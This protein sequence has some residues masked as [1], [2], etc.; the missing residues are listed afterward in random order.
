MGKENFEDFLNK[1]NESIEKGKKK[2]ERIKVI[3]IKGPDLER[4]VQDYKPEE[5][6]SPTP[7]QQEIIPP[8]KTI[9]MPEKT[10]SSN[11]KLTGLKRLSPQMFPESKDTK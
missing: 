5:F 11:K 7:P 9:K 4:E 6:T 2:E 10:P 3:S 8:E 1:L